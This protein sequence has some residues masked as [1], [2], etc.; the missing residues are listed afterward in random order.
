MDVRGST[1]L[2]AA[3]RPRR[4]LIAGPNIGIPPTHVSLMTAAPRAKI[5]SCT[6]GA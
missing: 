2:T 5:G 3:G 4:C 1:N 6:P